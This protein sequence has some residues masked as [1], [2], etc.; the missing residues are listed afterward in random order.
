MLGGHLE[1]TSMAATE[2]CGGNK[3]ASRS[4]DSDLLSWYLGVPMYKGKGE[5]VRESKEGETVAVQYKY[6]VLLIS[7]SFSSI[8]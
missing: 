2:S 6:S 7:N 5:R 3:I 1:Q 8:V 4:T